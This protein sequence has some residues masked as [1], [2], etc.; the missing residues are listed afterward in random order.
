MKEQTKH[1][2]EKDHHWTKQSS[3]GAH[4]VWV[5]LTKLPW[6]VMQLETLAAGLLS[7]IAGLTLAPW[8]QH[9]L[10]SLNKWSL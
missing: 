3:P 7:G 9:T 2:I 6:P 4:L 8:L 5:C 10:C 1:N